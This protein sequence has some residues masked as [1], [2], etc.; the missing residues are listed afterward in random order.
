MDVGLLGLSA[1]HG[2]IAPHNGPAL[3]RGQAYDVSALKY[4]ATDC[5]GS[6]VVAFQARVKTAWTYWRQRT[7]PVV[8]TKAC[9]WPAASVHGPG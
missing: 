7:S 1:F 8:F 5:V 4:G 3:R 6:A 9:S 2:L